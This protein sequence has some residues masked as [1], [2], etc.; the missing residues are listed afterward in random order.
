MFGGKVT[1]SPDD[2]DRL[3]DLAKKQIAAENREGELTAEVTKLK[4][5]NEKL[6]SENN[7]L[8]EQV[9]AAR[10]LKFSFSDLQRELET[11]KERY[12]KVIEFVESLG[13]KDKLERFLHFKSTSINKRR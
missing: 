1:I 10:S 7:T 13:L 8:R 9:Q 11:L 5:E 2:Y 12:R 6:S 3:T 4:K